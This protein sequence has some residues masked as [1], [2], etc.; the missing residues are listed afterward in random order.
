M[1]P[2]TT[3]D[4]LLAG[5]VV[6]TV[7]NPVVAAAVHAV[8]LEVQKSTMYDVI[9]VPPLFVGAVQFTVAEPSAAV[10][11]MVATALD[12]VKGRAIVVAYAPRPAVLVFAAMR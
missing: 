11:E 10:A 8:E 9:A 7:V 2:V 12:T 6:D 1:S 5:T 3:S 4:V